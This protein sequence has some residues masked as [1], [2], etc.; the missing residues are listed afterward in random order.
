VAVVLAAGRQDR[1]G[2]IREKRVGIVSGLALVRH[3][4]L[5]RIALALLAQPVGHA[6]GG[7]GGAHVDENGIAVG[8]NA[9]GD[10]VG[11]E[12][13]LEAPKGATLASAGSGAAIVTI[14]P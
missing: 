8:G 3:R 14:M 4:P 2:R 11:C 7:D 12:H 10:R 13:G 5:A 6:V 1:S 9:D